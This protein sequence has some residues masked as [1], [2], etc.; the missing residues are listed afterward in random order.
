MGF[1][2]YNKYKNKKV[3]IDGIRFDS[4]NEGGRYFELK[5]LEKAGEIYNLELQPEFII[6]PAVN[7][8]GKKFRARKYRADFKYI[9]NRGKTIVE[10][11]KGYQTPEYKLKRQLFLSV[12]QDIYTFKE[13][14]R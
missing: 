1:K 3:I 5:L 2:T 8:N 7:W 13:V 10:D 9:D 12:Y 11:F 4:K 6:C 14:Y